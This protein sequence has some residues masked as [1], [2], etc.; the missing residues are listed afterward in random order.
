MRKRILIGL[1]LLFVVAA[2]AWIV[3]MTLL[4]EEWLK[5]QLV[6]NA[7]EM[8]DIELAIDSLEFHPWQ[9]KADLKGVTFDLTKPDQHIHGKIETIGVELAIL[10]LLV[11]NVDVEDLT[12]TRPQV[13]YVLDRP[14]E[15]K[16]RATLDQV[17]EKVVVAVADLIARIVGEFLD[18]LG[19]KKGYDIRIKH[20]EIID[21]KLNGTLNRPGVDPFNVVFDDLRYSASDLRP[22]QRGFGVWGYLSRADMSADLRVGDTRI[23]LRQEFAASPRVLRIANLDL[24]QI[25]RLGSQE[26]AIVFK[27]GMLDL[28]YRDSGERFEID[29]RLTNL[30]LAKNEEAAFSDFLFMPVDHLIAY[31]EKNGG[32][33]DLQYT[34]D[35]K[36]AKASD[37]LE[38]VIAEVWKGMWAEI[39]RRF[40]A[41]A[42]EDLKDWKSKGTD[43]LRDFLRNKDLLRP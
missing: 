32:N 13:T 24:G 31:V 22:S 21:G 23:S 25:D 39:L 28:L 14:A 9:G 34:R 4:N 43:K 38:F 3:S 27:Q 10:P 17:V 2:A 30:Q 33:L 26:D 40:Q 37:D 16:R 42:G 15:P 19:G 8:F 1:A 11:R 18:A 35:K 20:L 5:K 7:R 41:E 12:I 6:T 29:A 36:N